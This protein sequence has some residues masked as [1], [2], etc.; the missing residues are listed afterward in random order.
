MQTIKSISISN[1]TPAMAFPLTVIVI[2]SMC[3][4]AYEDRKRHIED[5]S[6]NEAECEVYDKASKTFKKKMWREIRVGNVVKVKENEMIPCDLITL[7]SSDPKGVLYVETKGL[8]GETNLKIKSVHKTFLEEFKTDSD[9]SKLK[10]QILC[11]RPNNAIY[12][13]EGYAEGVVTSHQEKISLNNDF[14][15][16]RGMSL[17]NTNSIYGICIFT[18]HDTKVMQNSA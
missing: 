18:G 5:A 11:E 15:I 9:I 4:D 2:I 16:L 1:G 13:F 7:N 12:K 14:Q 3:K 8:D 6:E 17:R 10:G